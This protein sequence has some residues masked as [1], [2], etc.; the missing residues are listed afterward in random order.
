M[1][2]KKI[3]QLP[4]VDTPMFSFKYAGRDFGE[5][6][7]VKKKKEL[8]LLKGLSKFY[9]IEY[10]VEDEL[11]ITQTVSVFD[12]NRAVH[13]VLHFEN[14]TSQK[15][16]LLSDINDCDITIPLANGASKYVPGFSIPEDMPAI[17]SAN[18]SNTRRDDYFPKKDY[19]FD[20]GKL[21]YAPLRGR[22][23]DGIL[24]F[25]DLNRKKEG[26]MLTIGWTGQWNASFTRNNADI[27]IKSGIEDLGFRLEPGE[28]IR[29]A[30]ILLIGY[31]DG[32]ND[33]HNCLRKLIKENFSLI[34][35]PGRPK[36]GPLCEIAW[37]GLPSEKM[38]HRIKGMGVH[39]LGFEYYWI[40]AGWYGQSTQACPDNETGDWY[41]HTG[42]WRINHTYHPDG[43]VEV[44]KTARENNLK[45]MLWAEPERVINTTPVA[46]EHPEWFFKIEEDD[47]NWLLNLG[48]EEALSYAIG[49]LSAHIEKLGLSCYRQDFNM[50]PLQHWRE[51]DEPDRKGI[52]E[53]KHIMG[54]YSFWD[55][56]L[57]R[58]PDIII[59][60]CAGGGRRLDI[61]TLK[62]SI[63]LWRSDYQCTWD[64]EPE[65]TQI[66]TMGLSWWIP[67]SGTG[68]GNIIGD[69]YRFR[70]C[71]SAAMATAYWTFEPWEFIETQDMDWIRN[72]NEEFKLVRKYFSCDYYNLS[73][74]S[75]DNGGWTIW[76]YNDAEKGSGMIIAFRRS[77]SPLVSAQ[78]ALEGLKPDSSY[79]FV[80]M[81]T[82]ETSEQ[83]FAFL[84]ENGL[85]INLPD[86]R[87]SKLIHYFEAAK[88]QPE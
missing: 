63:P 56:L 26:V 67:Y 38:M 29:T 11:T 79:K 22:S 74:Q 71:Y 35:Q 8:P 49:V 50:C 37:G 18:G 23:S 54:L 28:K 60:N 64:I 14:K 52:N 66:H 33:G 85:S 32:K 10:L 87:S 86:K 13:W 39:D 44:A 20:G 72:S 83:S 51:N 34:G 15:T 47:K 21:N 75:M 36:E 55:A 53:I 45:L 12:N 4:E 77:E 81:D 6:N 73:T 27:R 80:D 17:Y 7:V 62:R 25:F 1:N 82:N 3:I 24:P 40:D 48:N 68:S 9:E 5:L 2:E 46:K 30:S 41:M 69:T 61:E 31:T 76:Q 42:D 43:L 65:A 16:Q 58:F 59:D 70:S 19:I 78:L 57:E 84:M 88:K